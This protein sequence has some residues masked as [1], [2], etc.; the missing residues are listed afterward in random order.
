MRVSCLVR[1]PVL[2]PSQKVR[3]RYDAH[4]EQS[5]TLESLVKHEWASEKVRPPPVHPTGRGSRPQKRTAT[6]GLLW[7]TRGLNF[8]CTA[9]RSSHDNASEELSA[10]FNKSYEGTLKKH[11]S[12][13][14]RP[15]FAVRVPSLLP[16]PCCCRPGLAPDPSSA[17]LSVRRPC[18]R[19]P[20]SFTPR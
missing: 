20:S 17:R 2:T 4:P 13:V 9:L 6:E 12:F 8:T 15:L 3:A 10:S 18:A 14:V 7:L 11:H 19:T 16:V 1:P 5:K